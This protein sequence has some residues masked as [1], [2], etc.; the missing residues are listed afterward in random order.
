VNLVV[1]TRRQG[2]QLWILTGVEERC[3]GARGRETWCGEGLEETDI[4]DEVGL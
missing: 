3:C 4:E 2:F 1:R